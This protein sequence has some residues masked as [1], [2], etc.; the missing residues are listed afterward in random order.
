MLYSTIKHA[1]ID[2]TMEKNPNSRTKTKLPKKLFIFKQFLR[3]NWKKIVSIILI[4]IITF[5]IAEYSNSAL[6]KDGDTTP[7]SNVFKYSARLMSEGGMPYRDSFD[8]KGPII[9]FINYFSRIF[10]LNRGIWIFEITAIFISLYYS[11]SIPKRIFKTNTIIALS[12]TLLCGTLLLNFE[13]ALNYPELFNLPLI[14]ISLYYFLDYLI[15]GNTNAKRVFLY[16]L[17][18]GISLM[19]K[20]N[21]AFF[22][23]IIIITILSRNVKAKDTKQFIRNILWFIFGTLV[24]VLPI[25]IWLIIN[26]AFEQFIDQVFIFNAQYSST[27]PKSSIGKKAISLLFFLENPILLS[28]II[29]SLYFLTQNLTKK[30]RNIVIINGLIMVISL[31]L[32][33]L[34]GAKHPHYAI[35]TIPFVIVPFFLLLNLVQGL[36]SN[37][38]SITIL[39]LIFLSYTAVITPLLQSLQNTAIRFDERKKPQFNQNVLDVCKI[40]EQNTNID[41][42][43]SVVGNWDLI[44]NKANRFSAS[45]YSY[46]Y[47]LFKVRPSITDEYLNDLKEQ[48]PKIIV[49]QPNRDITEIRLPEFLDDNNY[50][51]IYAETD[52]ET[53]IEIE[54]GAKVYRLME[55]EN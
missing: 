24:I 26:G 46:Q 48:L 32:C 27:G 40:I 14:F 52:K 36:K 1:T 43:I 6:W 44:Y 41:D 3:N 16:G 30:Q 34:S 31:L 55:P 51:L 39:I 22:W 7:D 38:K 25:I 17:F 20:P 4:L 18:M 21:G 23:P 15:N 33:A 28:S 47:D 45:K 53:G 10:S 12:I 11:Y 49:I 5:L 8:H 37:A 19:M 54:T 42:K 9:Y 13:D 35:I 29:I 2:S 50:K